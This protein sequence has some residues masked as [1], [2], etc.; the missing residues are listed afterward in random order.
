MH[1]NFNLY[2]LNPGCLPY[3]QKF[4][5]VKIK[6]RLFAYTKIKIKKKIFKFFCFGGED[7]WGLRPMLQWGSP[8]PITGFCFKKIKKKK[9]W[10]WGF[11]YFW[12]GWGV[13]PPKKIA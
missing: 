9:I 1:K 12:G 5:F 6:P 11:F 13:P 4:Q 3:T 7:S 10:K 8:T 2:K